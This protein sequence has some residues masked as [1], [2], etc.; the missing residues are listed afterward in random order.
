MEKLFEYFHKLLK[1]THTDFFRYIKDIN[2]RS[3]MIGITGPRGVGK[4][5]M[6]LQHIKKDLDVHKTLY[7]TAEDFY[8]ADHRLMELAEV[9][10]KQGGEFLFIDEIHQY[11]DWAKELKLI[12]LPPRFICCLYRI[13]CVGYQKGS[14]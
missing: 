4:T 3:R 9:F 1:E 13:F 14:R 5:T 11:K 10:V 8:F 7:I 2:W 6:V 12:Y